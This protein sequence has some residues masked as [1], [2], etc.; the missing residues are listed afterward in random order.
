[1]IKCVSSEFNGLCLIS[2][3][4]L[5]IGANWSSKLITFSLPFNTLLSYFPLI[6]FLPFRLIHLRINHRET[7]SSASF[8]LLFC[9]R[10]EINKSLVSPADSRENASNKPTPLY[11]RDVIY[12]DNA[13]WKLTQWLILHKDASWKWLTILP[14]FRS[15]NVHMST[16][17]PMVSLSQD[18][19]RST[20]PPH[21]ELVQNLVFIKESFFITSIFCSIV[22]ILLFIALMTFC[23]WISCCWK[24]ALSE[25]VV[26]IF[27][28]FA[29]SND[30][31]DM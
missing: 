5:I 31:W 24:N 4:E 30:M 26:V 17:K 6:I 23:V 1:M 13:K 20:L 9:L 7:G 14:I 10:C 18:K 12:I 2:S 27:N 11:K 28:F 29:M 22:T 16:V 15:L 21:G 8:H 3:T 25:T 19:R